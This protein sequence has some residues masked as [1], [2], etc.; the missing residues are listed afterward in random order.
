MAELEGGEAALALA[1]GMAAISGIVLSNCQERRP[2]R[3]ASVDVLDYD[4]FLHHIADRFQIEATFVD[5][6]EA[7]N[8][9]TANRQN[10][11]LFWIETPTN[12]LVQ[13]TD[14]EAVAAIA[15]ENDIVTVADNTFAT[16]FNQRPSS[17]ASTP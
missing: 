7:E 15:H 17:W 1:S 2:H 4:N 9:R 11:K 6:T 14:I 13:I 5:A 10:T 12:P 3:R 16:P 8:Y